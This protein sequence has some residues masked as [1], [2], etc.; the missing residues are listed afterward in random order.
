M[1]RFND[2]VTVIQ[3]CTTYRD[4][5]NLSVH[6]SVS[7]LA[8]C[9]RQMIGKCSTLARCQR[10]NPKPCF[11]HD[12]AEAMLSSPIVFWLGPGFLRAFS[13]CCLNL[14]PSRPHRPLGV[15]LNR[16]NSDVSYYPLQNSVSFKSILFFSKEN[17]KP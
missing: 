14:A 5:R 7:C 10:F 16:L 11:Y 15:E 3:N 1:V 2:R 6:G 8:P 4:R 12:N 9:Q 13:S 17:S